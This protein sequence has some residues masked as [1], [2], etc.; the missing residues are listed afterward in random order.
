[1]ALNDILNDIV[2]ETG[3]KVRTSASEREVVV[4][5]VNAAAKELYDSTDL[6]GSLDEQV[7]DLNAGAAQ[8]SL[9]EYVGQTR[10]GRYYDSRMKVAIDDM[11]NRYH[12][13]MNFQ[14]VWYLNFRK[15]SKSPLSREII[16]E[17]VLK[18][19]T[20]IEEL[21]DTRIAIIGPTINS[22]RAAEEIVLLANTKE[23]S[24][25]S[26]FRSPIESILK[27]R[28]TLY[29][30]TVKDIE[31]NILAVIPNSQYRSTYNIY[32]ILD[33]PFPT[34]PSTWSALEVKFKKRYVPMKEDIDQFVCGD[35]FD[36][37]IFWKFMEHRSRNV[38]A[39]SA[40][41]AKTIQATD[42]LITDEE[43]GK[44]RN[45]ELV[46]GPWWNLPYKVGYLGD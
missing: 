20:P 5:R 19:S 26:N 8:V 12:A 45:L 17:S 33:T 46:P 42:T 10:G 11:G 6:P 7:F 27:N 15:L 23:V 39:A 9:P 29:D 4:T 18:F 40:F 22:S 14:D 24:C 36:K 32:Q 1:M 34:L 37:A 28:K 41:Q 31:D 43:P 21:E 30:I 35:D 16:N 44:K 38:E 25:I 3:F 2:A 13:G